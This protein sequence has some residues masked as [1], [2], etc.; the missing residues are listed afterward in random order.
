LNSHNKYQVLDVE[1]V[2]DDTVV[3][4]VKHVHSESEGST[5]SIPK[6]ARRDSKS[7]LNSSIKKQ[8]KKTDKDETNKEERILARTA[9]EKLNKDITLVVQ[10][11]KIDSHEVV[12]GKALLDCGATGLFMDKQFAEKNSFTLQKLDFPVKVRNV[13]GTWNKGGEIT[14][15]VT[16]NVEY[17]GHQERAMFEICD[18]GKHELILGMT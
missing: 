10:L 15:E 4:L 16:T 7:V 17:Q 1:S 6:V 3:S 2:A 9:E 5:G 12:T 8:G 14:H 18:L 11:N 13:D